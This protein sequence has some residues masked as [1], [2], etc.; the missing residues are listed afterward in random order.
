MTLTRRLIAIS[1]AIILLNGTTALA[2][3]PFTL[4]AIFTYTVH[5]EI[6]FE[7]FAAGRIGVVQP[8]YARSY[9]YT[10]YRHL[11]GLNFSP[12]EQKALVDL[13]HER[14]GIDPN[15]NDGAS[16]PHP[17]AVWLEARK[18]VSGVQD[19]GEIDIYRAREKPNDYEFYVNC[20]NDS[21]ETA[22][23]TLADRTAEYKSDSAA[24]LT[25]ISAQ[26]QVFSNCSSGNSIPD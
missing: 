6:P 13:W 10:A 24:L 17:S 18:K 16:P 25:W 11:S 1:L 21:F 14:L 2:C 12:S 3:G 20:N 22:A 9:L 15:E 8:S 23:K 7:K 19:R 4:E 5:P 26:D